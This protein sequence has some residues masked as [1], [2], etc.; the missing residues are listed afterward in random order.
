VRLGV[1][2]SGLEGGQV[3]LL[4]VYVGFTFHVVNGRDIGRVSPP[5][6]SLAASR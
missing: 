4:R 3:A 2:T 6:G 1:A 5:F